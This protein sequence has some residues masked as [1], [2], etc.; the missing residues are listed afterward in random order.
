M[1]LAFLLLFLA[2]CD[3]LHTGFSDLEPAVYYQREKSTVQ[4][5]RSTLTVMTWNLKFAGGRIDFF[6][7]CH[8]NQV[9][10]SH[11]EVLQ[12]LEG[13]AAKIR[14]VDPDLLF[15]QEA[16]VSSKRSAYVDTVRWLLEHTSLQYGV[17]ASQWKADFVPSDGLGKVD[18]GNAILSRWPLAEATRH[19]LPL[20]E[21]Q[22]ELTSYFYLKRNILAATLT[23]PDGRP[24]RLANT[25]A[26]AYAKD[27][28][29]QRQLERFKALLDT[30]T[31]DGELFVAGGDLNTLP[32]GAKKTKDFP[33][34]V[35]TGTYEADDFSAEGAYLS[36]FF[37]DFEAAIPLTAYLAD[38]KSFFTHSTSGE[39][40]WNRTLDYLFAPAGTFV[41]G[42]GLVHQDEAHGE[43]ATMP[44]SDH[45]P[46]SVEVRLP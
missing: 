43:W 3:P 7:D 37:T 16:D 38:E 33:D 36:D 32:P 40:F 22:S 23:L 21:E 29:K 45:A 41:E 6:F 24:L 30:Y 9:L 26:E 39:E 4:P 8:G 15:L 2:A 20:I 27:G 31:E 10:M 34:S 17:Y 12:H 28:T 18:S 11:A 44:L 35:C 13:L 14:Q 1:P 5:F 25:H 19:A 46:L 42:S